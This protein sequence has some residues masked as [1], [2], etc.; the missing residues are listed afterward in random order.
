M[1]TLAEIKIGKSFKIG[2][3]EFIK[4]DELDGKAVVITKECIC[5][6]FYGKN[7][8]FS[9]SAILENLKT[10][11]LPKI[12]NEI[13]KE[14]IK[15]FELDITSFDGLDTY[16]KIKTEIGLL[17]LD[18]YRRYVRLFDQ[19]KLKNWWWLSTPDSTPEHTN[20]K[21]LLCVAPSGY[22]NDCNYYS[23]NYGVRPFLHFVSSI[24]VS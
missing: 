9:K 23:N 10:D 3:T 22:V 16:G 14:N 11:F 15:E 1:K 5:D 24:F 7:N 21:W 6:S 18:M 20:D 19:Y 4:L 2:D 17:T 13:G 8:D 12:K